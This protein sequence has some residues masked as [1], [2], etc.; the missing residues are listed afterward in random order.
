MVKRE[1]EK[2]VKAD[3]LNDFRRK[4]FEG[5]KEFDRSRQEVGETEKLDDTKGISGRW[6]EKSGN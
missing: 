2:G 4:Y 5:F 1:Y 3:D 6:R